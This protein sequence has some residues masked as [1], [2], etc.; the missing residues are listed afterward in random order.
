[1]GT[2]KRPS[3]LQRKAKRRS[4]SLRTKRNIQNKKIKGR[5][6]TGFPGFGGEGHGLQRLSESSLCL[7]GGLCKTSLF[8]GQVTVC[9]VSN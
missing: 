4:P 3:V 9:K 8:S 5:L 6:T 7:T 1:M 2:G